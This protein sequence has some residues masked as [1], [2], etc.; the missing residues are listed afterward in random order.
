[1]YASLLTGLWMAASA[2][3]LGLFQALHLAGVIAAWALAILLSLGIGWRLGFLHKGF[4]RLSPPW[5]KPSR[6]SLLFTLAL[7]GILA[8]LLLTAWKS[9]P[10]N[11]DSL[12]YHMSRVMHWAQSGSLA[13]HPTAY[14]P[15]LWSPPFAEIAVLHLRILWGND[16]PA[17]LVQWFAYLGVLLAIPLVARQMGAGVNGQRAAIAF[18]AALPMGILEATSTQ[19]EIVLAYLLLCLVYLVLEGMPRQLSTLEIFLLGTA[20]GLAL[21]TK[22]FSYL[23]AFPFML[24]YFG[25][26]LLRRQYRTLIQHGLLA[27]A[28]AIALNT[29]F[30]ARNIATFGGP[31]G[32]SHW[33]ETMAST[34]YSLGSLAA[35]L[36]RSV[37]HNLAVPSASLNLRTT[38]TVEAILQLFGQG[39]EGFNLEWAWNH[40]ELA[41]SPHYL[42]LA[43]LSLV[44]LA[45][46][47]KQAVFLPT[48]F[49][50]ILSCLVGFALLGWIVQFNIA[51]LRYQ[52]PFW[53]LWAPLFGAA[54]TLTGKRRWAPALLAGL[55]ILALP[56][57]LFNRFRPLIALRPVSEPLTLPCW[58]GCTATGSILVEPPENILFARWTEMRYPFTAAADVLRA[59]N[60]RQVGLAIDSHQI[61]YVFWYLLEAPQSGFHLETV[62][63]S[64]ET[65]VLLNPDFKP[66]AILCTLCPQKD[67]YLS[68]PLYTGFQLVN[69]Y[70]DDSYR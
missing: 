4:T 10:N 23:Y 49:A 28:I 62:L 30:W 31:L 59:K 5:N 39:L 7:G 54:C 55:L 13:H 44:I 29:G 25:R 57:V 34:R 41:G 15:Q 24:W 14:N 35:G 65:Q 60:C 66:C 19:N 47:R 42:I 27:A 26:M 6:S 45:A 18:A 61:E 37:A 64:T 70:L 40:E 50:Y 36:V 68:L 38:Q 56:W 69:I 1:M 17:N 53:V 46:R 21:L 11:I 52:Y 48:L 22:G 2:E 12:Q 33:I 58:L 16:Q 9:P 67:T 8:L 51:G 20:L 32:S 43:A 3:V 63:A